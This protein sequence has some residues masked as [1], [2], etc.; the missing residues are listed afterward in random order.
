MSTQPQP[1]PKCGNTMEAGFIVDHGHLNTTQV[2]TWVEGEPKKSF[3]AGVRIG[4][5][6]QVPVTTYR[7]Q[8]CGYLEAYAVIETVEE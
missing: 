2:E 6:Q 8:G 3:W 4:D 7:C 5:R 1:C